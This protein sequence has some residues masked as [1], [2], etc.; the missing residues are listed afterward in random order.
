MPAV[1]VRAFG[2]AAMLA[3]VLA[4]A[5]SAQAA[6]YWG[7]FDGSL[8][9]PVAT[10]GAANL[11]GSGANP[12]YLDDLETPG[13]TGVAC[14]VSVTA[15]DLYWAGDHGIGR[16][17]LDGPAAPV[18]VV[19]GLVRPCG[20]TVD[21]S[22]VYWG[23]IQQGS[24]GRANLDGSEANPAF[25]SGLSRPCDVAVAGD[26]LYWA[27]P[28]GIGRVRLDGSAPQRDFLPGG[29]L[30][31]CGFAVRGEY[32]YWGSGES[33]ARARLDGSEYEPDFI[34]AT[35]AVEGIATDAS[36]IYWVDHPPRALSSIGRAGLDGSQPNRAWI[37]ADPAGFLL[38][39]QSNVLGVAVD[40]RPAPPPLLHP[41]RPIRFGRAAHDSRAGTVVLDVWVPDWGA[42]EVTS[43]GLRHRV[44]ADTN[45]HPA[46]GGALR[47]RVHLRPLKGRGGRRIRTRLKRRGV[48]AVT[49]RATYYAERTNPV[50]A[51]RR[52]KLRQRVEHRRSARGHRR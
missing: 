30:R 41:E 16:V 34:A 43:P 9:L 27:E 5:G 15:T 49:V 13:A 33:I 38:G 4:A 22:H 26:Y 8:N 48:A 42:L 18:T 31:G 32:V 10:V 47:W 1:L 51:V 14:G 21:Q 37:P 46:R 29:P 20:L 7:L 2:F 25:V 17:N 24:I 23:G 3:L 50:G 35:G 36:Y 44:I 45:P 11:D 19:P 52:L 6:V 39:A 40:A 12:N 28:L